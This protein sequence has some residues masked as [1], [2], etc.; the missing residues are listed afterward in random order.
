[1][2]KLLLVLLSG[3]ALVGNSARGQVPSLNHTVV[4]FNVNTFGTNFGTLDIELF[5]QEKPESVRNFLMYIYS[6]AYNNIALQNLIYNPTEQFKVMEA[7]RVR[8]ENP[9]S[10]DIFSSYPL[11]KDF[12]AI[13]NE[14][15]VGPEL[16][17]VFGTIATVR[18]PGQPNSAS[19]AWAFNMTNNVTFDSRD[20]GVTVFGRV[21]N[22]T[23]SRSGTNLLN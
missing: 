12:G 13:T 10:T 4:R 17:N 6:G 14:Y 22:T 23:D 18:F 15:S 5:D 9:T 7:G 20:G 11:W 19:H 3:L 8:I 1:V 21:V 16:S 2:K